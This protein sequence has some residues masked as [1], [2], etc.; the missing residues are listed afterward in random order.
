[1]DALT[2]LW[3][4]LLTRNNWIRV[5]LVCVVGSLVAGFW[6]GGFV[7]NFLAE[8]IGISLGAIITVS[9][10]EAH[11]ERTRLSRLATQRKPHLQHLLMGLRMAVARLCLDVGCPVLQSGNPF[12]L[13]G[14]EEA[15]RDW[16][17]RAKEQTVSPQINMESLRFGLGYIQ[18]YCLRLPAEE[19]GALS[20]L[21]E[22]TPH[23]I[24]GTF[25]ARRNVNTALTAL[26]AVPPNKMRGE[27]Y[28]K[29]LEMLL[30]ITVKLIDFMVYIGTIQPSAD[31][32]ADSLRADS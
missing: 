31:E 13:V 8:V 16:F 17:K 2:G 21:Y 32:P 3:K 23:V 30:D 28:E 14:K 29:F 6:L 12:D 22:D 26:L 19:I 1:M 5:F 24:E 9:L 4:W 7:S 27:Y 20:H 15:I 10:I 25:S 11:I 18:N